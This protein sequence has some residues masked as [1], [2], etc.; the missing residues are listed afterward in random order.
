MHNISKLHF[1]VVLANTADTAV[2]SSQ[3]LKIITVNCSVIQRFK[4]V[5]LL[6]FELTNQ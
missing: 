6:Y 2:S 1:R 4:C 5:E 3:E